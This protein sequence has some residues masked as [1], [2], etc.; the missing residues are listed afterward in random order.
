[1]RNEC[2]AGEGDACHSLGTRYIL[3]AGVPRSWDEQ[4][5]YYKRAFELHLTACERPDNKDFSPCQAAGS[6]LLIGEGV[7]RSDERGMQFIEKARALAVA[8][9]KAGDKEACDY[10]GRTSQ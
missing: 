7:E 5:R 6:A 3:G 1:M 2:A 10:S 9:C 8:Q 4:Q